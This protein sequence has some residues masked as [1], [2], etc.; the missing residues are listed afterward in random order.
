MSGFSLLFF[1]RVPG[2]GEIKAPKYGKS[3]GVR[4]NHFVIAVIP[5]GWPFPLPNSS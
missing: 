5:T 1:K 2:S 4:Q 3:E